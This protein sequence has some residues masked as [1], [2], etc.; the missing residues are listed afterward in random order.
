MWLGT[1]CPRNGSRGARVNRHTEGAWVELEQGFLP[2]GQMRAVLVDI[3]RGDH[4]QRFFVGVRVHR[5]F[6]RAFKLDAGRRAQPLATVG[7]DGAFGI[8]FFLRTDAGQILA[9][10]GD[11][12]SGCLGER[13]GA[14]TVRP[15][16]LRASRPSERV[17]AW[18]V[19]LL[20]LSVKQNPVA[21]AEGCVGARSGPDTNHSICRYGCVKRFTVAAR[22]NAAC[23]SCYG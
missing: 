23:I 10:P 13:Q 3:L 8:A 2:F 19:S 9:Q 4:K 7:R 17:V 5:V 12:V 21:A 1:P 22:P 6:A 14:V 11:L 15:E 18:G 16:R 20:F